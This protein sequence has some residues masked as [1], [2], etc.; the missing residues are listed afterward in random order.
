MGLVWSRRIRTITD[1]SRPSLKL[2]DP[3]GTSGTLQDHS[4]PSWIFQESYGPSLTLLDILNTPRSFC[5]FLDLFRPTDPLRHFWTILDP[6]EPFRDPSGPSGTL[7]VPPGPPNPPG[8][9]WTLLDPPGP[10]GTL[11]VLLDPYGP[12]LNV[13]D[14]TTPMDPS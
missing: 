11:L 14:P 9:Y 7:P 13:P 12:S 5:T 6:P 3:P 10:S 2:L 4:R 8:P 1:P